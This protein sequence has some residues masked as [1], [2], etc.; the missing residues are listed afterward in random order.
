MRRP[1]MSESGTKAS[2]EKEK[3]KLLKKIRE[4][5][6]LEERLANGEVLEDNQVSSL[7]LGC[8]CLLKF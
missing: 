4:T 5:K 2:L 6:Q 1:G 7:F 8:F 3:H